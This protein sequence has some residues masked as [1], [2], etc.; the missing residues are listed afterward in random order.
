MLKTSPVTVGVSRNPLRT[1]IQV[2]GAEHPAYYSETVVITAMKRESK[3]ALN[4]VRP[5]MRLLTGNCG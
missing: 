4:L 3:L 1:P 2:N 5:G